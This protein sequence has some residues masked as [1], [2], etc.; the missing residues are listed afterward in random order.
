M[1]ERLRDP[2]RN[3]PHLRFFHARVVTAGS[4]NANPAR[5]HRRIY[6]KRNRIFVDRNAGLT[7]SFLRSLP[8]MPFA[9]TST[10]MR[11]VSVPLEI[12]R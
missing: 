6:I 12:M 4:A 3:L 7:E 11:C 10:S 5:F 9:N 2:V 8:S 1:I